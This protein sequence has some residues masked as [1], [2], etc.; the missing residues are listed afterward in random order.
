MRDFKVRIKHT[1]VLS[2]FSVVF[3]KNVYLARA[4]RDIRLKR[5]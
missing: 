5:K 4:Q 1:I 3:Q 2:V